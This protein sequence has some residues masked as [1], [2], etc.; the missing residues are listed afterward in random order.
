M[1]VYDMDFEG[2]YARAEAA[3]RERDEECE[4]ARRFSELYAEAI[5]DRD[6]AVRLLR[7]W[8]ALGAFVPDVNVN[9]KTEQFLTRVTTDE[10]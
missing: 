5:R 1:S 4:S 10:T 2:Q 8:K 6:E 9:E 3:E 7:R